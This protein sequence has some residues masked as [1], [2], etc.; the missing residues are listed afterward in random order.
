[1]TVVVALRAPEPGERDAPAGEIYS[2]DPAR[3]PQRLDEP[4]YAAYG[5]LVEQTPSPDPALEL[6]APADIGMGPHLFYALQW[7]SF[8]GIALVGYVILLRREARA[9][10][11]EAAEPA[12]GGDTPADLRSP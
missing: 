2:I 11:V 7:W 8:I 4:V 6:P 1:V 10:E 12:P 3:Y 9:E 5:D